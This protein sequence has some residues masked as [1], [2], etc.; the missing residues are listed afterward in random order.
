MYGAAAAYEGGQDTLLVGFHGLR[1]FSSRLIAENLRR[2]WTGR[3]RYVT[4]TVPGEKSELYN[5]P[6][7]RSLENP[8]K[9]QSLAEAVLP[10]IQGDEAVGLPAVLG[11]KDV[12]RVHEEMESI[13]NRP[14][15]E[16]PTMLPSVTGMRLREA[17][18]NR[19]R[20]LGVDAVYQAKVIGFERDAAG[21]FVFQVGGEKPQTIVRAKAAVLATGRFF[22]RGLEADRRRVR[23][24][25]F[26]LPVSQPPDREDWYSK[27]YFNPAGHGINRAGIEIDERFRPVG[28]DGR[29]VYENLFAAGSILAHQ[30]WKRQKCGGGL[31]ITTAMAA[32]RAGHSFL[33]GN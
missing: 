16:I 26:G 15:F 11:I 1:G 12:R 28:P 14:V 31:A 8:S 27:D 6:L 2:C 5:E 25:V 9:L 18:A 22:G 10:A 32:V 13:L 30:D 4:V 19:L 3:L 7:A 21:G 20:I 24:T 23:E 29:P 33:G 17:F